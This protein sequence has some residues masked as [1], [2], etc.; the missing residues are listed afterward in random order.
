M[1]EVHARPQTRAECISGPRPCPFVS[2]RH[3]L[4]LEV[5]GAGSIKFNFDPEDESRESCSLD[6]ADRGP[7]TVDETGVALGVSHARIEQIE[8]A[9]YSKLRAAHNEVLEE[10]ADE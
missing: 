5:T 8:Q 7:L 1:P 10:L 9:A 4:A 6:V 3:H 2:C